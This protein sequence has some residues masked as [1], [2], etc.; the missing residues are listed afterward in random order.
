MDTVLQEQIKA[1]FYLATGC[2][3]CLLFPIQQHKN[4]VHVGFIRPPQT[5]QSNW[6][7]W[8]TDC[9]S[10]WLI[11]I[12]RN[13]TLRPPTFNICMCETG[14]Q[15]RRRQ[16]TVSSLNP[17]R[18]K[19]QMAPFSAGRRCVHMC[20]FHTPTEREHQTQPSDAITQ[21]IFRLCVTMYLPPH[22]KF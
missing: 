10:N 18:A 8:Q 7:D 6:Y 5:S 9:P 3:W 11:N 21:D 16:M 4:K 13:Y 12:D 17:P 20:E 14:M 22:K 2:H 1:V 15:S 19:G